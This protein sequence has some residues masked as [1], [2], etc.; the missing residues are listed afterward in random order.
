[1]A[2]L[3]GPGDTTRFRVALLSVPTLLA[4]VAVVWGVVYRSSYYTGVDTHLE[5]PVPFSHQHHVSGLGLDCRYC[6]T[7]VEDSAFAGMPATKTC[8]RCHSQIWSDSPTLAPVRESYR[9]E[10]PLRW[11]RVN[12][13]PDYVYFDHSI[14]VA[15]GIGCSTCHGHVDQMPLTAR[16]KSLH[17]R[18]CI[19]CHRNPEPYM[20]PRDK[21]FDMTYQPGHA[22]GAELAQLDLPRA[23]RD[24]CWI[25]H[26]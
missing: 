15:K 5:Q 2:K 11:V 19:D 21:V 14:H 22:P 1:V 6:H 7:T 3:F 16:A 8:M 18:W 24:D 10:T 20:R 23:Q 26:R 17:M 25:C 4:A 13:L 9:T 12:V